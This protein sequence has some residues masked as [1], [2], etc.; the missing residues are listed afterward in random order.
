MVPPDSAPVVPEG[1]TPAPRVA[2]SR[3]RPRTRERR[4]ATADALIESTGQD[5]PTPAVEVAP[6]GRTTRTTR[7][8]AET[9]P[10]AERNSAEVQ[11]AAQPPPGTRSVTD[12]PQPVRRPDGLDRVLRQ[13]E[14]CST[15][16]LSRTTIWRLER[17]GKFP[18]RRRLGRQAVGWM[19]GDVRAWL[20]ARVRLGPGTRERVRGEGG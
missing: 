8:K 15:T 17:D 3:A 19:E 20:E 13:P 6:I 2:R 7:T 16:G 1:R 9:P 14:V 4:G 18:K 11:A 12:S 5:V 10:S